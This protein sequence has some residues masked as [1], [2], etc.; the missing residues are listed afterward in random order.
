MTLA[1][2]A[3]LCGCAERRQRTVADSPALAAKAPAAAGQPACGTPQ[4]CFDAGLQADEAKES[5]RA[6][7]LF[8]A[9]CEGGNGRGCLYFASPLTDRE[10]Q[11]TYFKRACELGGDRFSDSSAGVG[12]F[13]AAEQSYRTDVAGALLLYKKACQS[14]MLDGCER[15]SRLAYENERFADAALL[16]RGGCSEKEGEKK[17]SSC[18][19]LGVLHIFGKGVDKDYELAQRYLKRGC[20]AHDEEA[21]KNQKQL[22]ENL[23]K[24]GRGPQKSDQSTSPNAGGKGPA[25]SKPPTST[26]ER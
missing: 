17:E 15:G 10:Q 18:G 19:L 12:C 7:P 5:E 6:A 24:V 3:L 21:C 26:R 2:A 20:A 23:A 4:A 1:L 16:A 11:L 25:R 8:R 22:A 14:G 9:A 13:N